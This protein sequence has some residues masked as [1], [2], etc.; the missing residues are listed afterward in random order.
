MPRDSVQAN[1][2]V[3]S[4]DLPRNIARRPPPPPPQPF[5]TAEQA[6]VWFT[7]AQAGGE[8]G[9]V[10]RACQP[11]AVLQ[12]IDRL[13][14]HRLLLRDH[15]L[16]LAHYGRRGAAPRPQVKREARACTLWSEAVAVLEAPLRQLGLLA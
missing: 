9:A 5:A 11:A 2:P 12:Q 1:E 4:A 14:R 8:I 6:L 13:W 15:L 7:R 3:I 16:V 10:P